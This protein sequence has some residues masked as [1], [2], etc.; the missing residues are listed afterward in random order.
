MPFVVPTLPAFSFS[1]WGNAGVSRNLTPVQV[2]GT[3][4][5]GGN[6]YALPPAGV[7]ATLTAWGFRA[8][9]A[10]PGTTSLAI[11]AMGFGTTQRGYAETFGGYAR[12]YGEVAVTVEEFEPLKPVH[13]GLAHPPDGGEEHAEIARPPTA[14]L[15][16]VVFKRSVTSAPTIIIN[17]ETTAIGYQF[18]IGDG[19]S[20]LTALV[21]PITPGNAYRLPATLHLPGCVRAGG[22]GLEHRVRLWASLFRLRL[23]ASASRGVG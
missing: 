17:Q 23:G 7:E 2:G 8:G 21:M 1:N 11:T 5:I 13:S 6:L 22:G 9:S 15:G 12:A 14:T 4:R 3:S 20:H 10:P 18:H 16:S 19:A